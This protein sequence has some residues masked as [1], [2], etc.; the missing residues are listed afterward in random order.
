MKKLEKSILLPLLLLRFFRSVSL[1]HKYHHGSHSLAI[2]DDSYQQELEYQWASRCHLMDHSNCRTGFIFCSAL[3]CPPPEANL[4]AQSSQPPRFQALHSRPLL[5]LPSSKGETQHL[6][7]VIEAFLPIGP[8]EWEL[9]V[10][11]HADHFFNKG[12]RTSDS[13][14]RKFNGLKS[15]KKPTG[16]PAI[17]RCHQGQE[18]E[19]DHISDL[20]EMRSC[21]H[22]GRRQQPQRNRSKF[23]K[24][25]CCLLLFVFLPL[26]LRSKPILSVV[27]CHLSFVLRSMSAEIRE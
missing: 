1:R 3:W 19:E 25:N 21:I 10:T 7:H 5:R 2:G 12:R 26:N 24:N 4:K 18:G 6:L 20:Q 9:V 15:N 8:D 23:H 16:D 13:L 11:A 14:R 27:I 22:H 17:P